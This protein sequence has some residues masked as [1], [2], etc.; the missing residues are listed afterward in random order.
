MIVSKS[1]S[2]FIDLCRGGRHPWR[3]HNPLSRPGI[4]LYR[5][6]V[7]C[8]SP[9]C[10]N[11]PLRRIL[12]SS[13]D[14]FFS[15]FGA[16]V[17]MNVQR[18]VSKL[19]KAGVKRAVFLQEVPGRQPKLCRPAPL[20]PGPQCPRQRQYFPLCKVI[21]CQKWFLNPHFKK[22]EKLQCCFKP[23]TLWYVYRYRHLMILALKKKIGWLLVR[24]LG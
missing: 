11:R 6:A 12:A 18:L 24:S 1:F 23:L 10:Q 3:W 20:Q 13:S 22:V 2:S 8:Q 21:N 4:A 16:S 5:T 17:I 14:I 7:A 19:A 9:S 15:L